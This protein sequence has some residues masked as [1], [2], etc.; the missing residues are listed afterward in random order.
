MN[1]TATE[2][3]K[4]MEQFSEQLEGGEDFNRSD[5]SD[6]YDLA[7]FLRTEWHEL[8]KAIVIP[9]EEKENLYSS[10]VWVKPTDETSTK[11]EIIASTE[12]EATAILEHQY[13]SS[14]KSRVRHDGKAKVSISDNP[15]PNYIKQNHYVVTTSLSG[16]Y[17]WKEREA[18]EKDLIEK[19]RTGEKVESFTYS[20]LKVNG[21]D[22]D[23]FEILEHIETYIS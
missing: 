5:I 7:D 21:S 14:K 1:Y 18:A 22:A 3:E 10:L 4:H 6:I 12:A 8:R 9:K 19:L 23:D 20:K 13:P 17:W 11:I 15:A 2:V 16:D